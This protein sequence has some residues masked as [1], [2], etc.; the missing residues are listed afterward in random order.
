MAN[1]NELEKLD[2]AEEYFHRYYEFED[3]V[4]ISEEN[5]EYL[6]T[7]IHDNNYVVSNFNFRSKVAKSTAISFGIGAV[8]FLL[9]FAILGK[10][11]IIVPII[12]FVSLFILGSVFGYAFNKFNLTQAEKNQVEVNEGIKEQI[13]MLQNRIT[14]CKKQRDDFAKGLQERI[15]FMSIDYAKYIPNLKEIIQNGEAETCE[16]AVSVLDQKLIMKKMSDIMNSNENSKPVSDAEKKERF[17]D[18][19]AI[20]KENKK[21]K[22]KEKFTN[23]FSSKH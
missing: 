19:L 5:K 23:I 7:Y 4:T 15:P 13:D 12:S 10:E 16:D 14:Q 2:Q 6:N 11:L 1:Q 17:G 20:I 3:A 18:P 21:K 9:L 8:V 22:R